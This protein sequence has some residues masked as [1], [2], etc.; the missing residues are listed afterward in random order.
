MTFGV[1]MGKGASPARWSRPRF[2][3]RGT[4]TWYRKYQSLKFLVTRDR[5]EVARFLRASYPF[6]FPLRDRLR[7]LADI[8]K[9]TN[10]V[11]GYHTL[12]EILRV[13]H[14]IFL[15]AGRD[16]LTVVECGAGSGSSTAKLSLATKIAGG[17]L[18]VFD[19]FQGIPE[20]DEQHHLLDG[21][22]L[23]FRRGAFKGRLTAV[24]KR[25][26]EFGV[27]ELCSFHKGLFADT[28]SAFDGHVDVALF[29]VD[30][31]SSTE[32]CTSH[33]Y[34]RLRDGGA[35]FSQDGHLRATV[36]LYE[37]E[38]YWAGMPSPPPKIDGLG[39]GKMLRVTKPAQGAS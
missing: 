7:F 2:I 18:V 5:D 28:L 1:S 13:C 14:H 39:T 27:P 32:Q 17:R 22:E 21:R 6:D 15:C 3:K 23:V 38:D 26:A 9:T 25:V 4:G 36:D 35:I 31:I 37:R 33:F 20:N 11:R 12:E 10:A 29:D 34:P 16:D 19:S 30:L 8:T 24:K